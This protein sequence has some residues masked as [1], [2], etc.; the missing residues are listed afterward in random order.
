MP[1]PSILFT[2]DAGG[3]IALQLWYGLDEASWPLPCRRPSCYALNCSSSVGCI[4]SSV[5][6]SLTQQMGW[7]TVNLE[8]DCGCPGAWWSIF[9][10]CLKTT[11]NTW[12]RVSATYWWGALSYSCGFQNF[13]QIKGGLPERSLPAKASVHLPWFAPAALTHPFQFERGLL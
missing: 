2:S 4:G 8:R 6:L 13:L 1:F 7:G 10:V 9:C 11:E 3:S 5:N 12:A